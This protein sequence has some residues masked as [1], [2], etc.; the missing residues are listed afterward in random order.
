[1]TNVV[2]LKESLERLPT[3]INGVVVSLSG[4]L[5]STT[6][7]RLAVHKYGNERVFAISFDYGQK[8]RRELEMAA[9]STTALGVKH[10][11]FKLDFL[12]D[13]NK[14][15]SAN[16]DA[17][18]AMPTIHDVL[19]DPQPVT[20]VANRNMILMSIAASF[21]ETHD[22]DVI[23]AG[24]QSNDEYNYWDTTQ[25][26]QASLNSV[27]ENN[28]QKSIKIISP[29]VGLNKK[30]EILSVLELDGN[31][32]LFK[33][34][35]TCYNPTPDGKSCGTCPSCAERLAAFQKLGLQDPIQYV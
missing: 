22:C 4:G 14:G 30:E 17:D 5:D 35:L 18:I 24:F 2:Y 31:L 21:A 15:F 25:K 32:D 8:Q 11:I 10:Q 1:M 9:A 16:I 3:S 34:T 19:G 23:L 20:Y 7:L 27:L 28:R 26:F 6:A 13:I 12:R 33:T 29:F